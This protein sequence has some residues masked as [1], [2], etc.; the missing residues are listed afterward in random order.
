MGHSFRQAHHHE[1]KSVHSIWFGWFNFPP[2]SE[3]VFLLLFSL[4]HTWVANKTW[5]ENRCNKLYRL[6]QIHQT[7]GN[8]FG[9]TRITPHL[10]ATT[11]PTRTLNPQLLFFGSGTPNAVISLE[12]SLGSS[13][14]IGLTLEI[15][16]EE[17]KQKLQGDNYNCVLCNNNTQETAFHLFFSCPFSQS[18]WQHLGISWDFSLEFFQM[19][20]QAKLQYQSTFFM[21]IFTIVA[22]EI[23]K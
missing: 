14:W 8:T 13:S 10:N 12:S 22:Q 23:W 19:M 3:C 7:L 21:E 17:K 18:C 6:I 20:H 5:T 4:L 9:E 16:L 2:V 11:C 1:L 15:F